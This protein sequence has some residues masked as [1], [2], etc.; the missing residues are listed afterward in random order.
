MLVYTVLEI[1]FLQEEIIFFR[2]SDFRFQTSNNKPG[3]LY[4]TNIVKVVVVVVVIVVVAVVEVVIVIV[5]SS[6]SKYCIIII[7]IYC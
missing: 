3:N 2:F 1:E 6:S 5:Y 7:T 4:T